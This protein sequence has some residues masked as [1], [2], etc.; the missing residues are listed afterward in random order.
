[1]FMEKCSSLFIYNLKIFWDCF[2]KFV[3]LP[4]F[5]GGVG[6]ALNMNGFLPVGGVGNPPFVFCL[7]I[8]VANKVQTT[9]H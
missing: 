1:M 5:S 9:I 7:F 3:T 2:F 4:A 8:T 6:D